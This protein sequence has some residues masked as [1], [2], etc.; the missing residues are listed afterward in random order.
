MS[1]LFHEGRPHQGSIP[2]SGRYEWG[3][4]ENPYQRGDF[5]YEVSELQKKGISQE[6]IAKQLGMSVSE[7]R[8]E[9]TKNLYS[10]YRQRQLKGMSQTQIAKDLG[11]STTEL[12]ARY[13][14]SKDE[15]K[16]AQ[17][18][19]AIDLKAKGYSNVEIAKRLG[20][21]DKTVGN[22]LDPIA[23]EKRDKVRG[24]AEGLKGQVDKKLYLDVGAGAER[25]LGGISRTQ[26]NASLA[27][28]KEEGYKIHYIKVEQ[29]TNPGKYTTVKVLTKDDVSYSEARD[30]RDKVQPITNLYYVSGEKT[31][32][33][34]EDPIRINPDRIQIRYK[35]D[36]GSKKDGV[37]EL[38][39][40][41][42]DLSMDGNQYAQVRI[43]VEGDKYL[44]G[45]A[46]YNNN[47]PDGV[48][49]IFNTNKSSDVPKMKVL[50]NMAD[51]T[52]YIDP[53]NPFGSNIRKQYH[54]ISENGKEKLSAINVVNDEE[55]WAKWSKS[56]A[57][58]FLSKQNPKLAE[59]QLNLDYE[60]RKTEYEQIKQVTNPA[61]K[62]RLL[63]AFA[64]ECDSAAV[65][66]KAA[67][68]PRQSTK[69]ILPVDS[70][71]DN[72]VYA[73]TYKDG[74][75]VILVRYPHGGLFEIPRLKVNNK[76]KEG[77]EV[78][79]QAEK[80]IGINAHVAEQ[81]SGADFD[82]D[83]V[84]VIPTKGQNILSKKPL[85][86]LEGYDPKE[87]YKAYE[88]M[89]KTED[90]VNF[91]KQTEMGK[92]SN[93]IT[94]MT[95]K[96]ASDAEIAR[97]VKHSMTVIDAD[98]HNLD[99]KRSAIENDIKELK[100]TWQ[101]G[102]NRG[103]STLIS[104]A[105]SEYDVPRR[106]DRYDIDKNTGKK[107]YLETGEKKRK[108][109]ENPDG[110]YT[111][112]ETDKPK[113]QKSTKMEEAFVEGKDAYYLSSGTEIENIY[114]KYANSCKSLGNEARKLYLDT[115][116]QTY[117]ST[118]R[119]VYKKEYE[120]LS[121][122]LDDALKVAPYERQAQLI[123]DKIVSEKVRANPEIK[124][125]KDAYQKLKNQTLAAQ[126]AF[127]GAGK[128]QHLVEITDK[129]WEAIQAGAIT[130]SMLSEIMMNTDLDALKERAT[131]K[132]P[133]KIT[134]AM[135]T[136]IKSYYNSGYTQAE[137]AEA[138][139]VSTSTITDVLKE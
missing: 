50:K 32:R 137:I 131:P 102:A 14:I 101:G 128:K 66:L 42:D 48:D 83:T 25:Q 54:Y 82:G 18:S 38:R 10:E 39:P 9:Y 95:I 49:I 29:A 56:L 19:K 74:E 4:G 73:P 138:L 116:G 57:S 104:K 79:G 90:G 110:T 91:N 70:L 45:M 117:D 127:A 59:R 85:P 78:V 41:V 44:K 133:R 51:D 3:S 7:L 58:Q 136:R 119:K 84:V 121:K 61:V 76:N 22:Y 11:I 93:L 6:D 35:E 64:D 46:I 1:E 26:F 89:P 129:E 135:K 105:S 23:A 120:S 55:E 134:N 27:L 69:V 112:I 36:G 123:T 28:L 2:H 96:G 130:N 115:K 106:K 30:N 108:K 63:I 52:G 97:A 40:N 111:W 87:K 53:D 88:G 113:L 34:I 118:A 132:T 124:N 98:K 16:K 107:L 65:N 72:E 21:T 47:L 94:D 86:Q 109:V 20:V 17:I 12:R 43:A 80:A 122:K 92:V 81:L 68:L 13:T 77:K 15:F 8:T 60:R 100:K 31:L 103:A 5:F 126:R 62:K 71:K 139:G 33:N 24:I 37:I 67:A 125:D 99:W 75:E 114:A